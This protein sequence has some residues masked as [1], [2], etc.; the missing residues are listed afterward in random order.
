MRSAILFVISAFI[1]ITICFAQQENVWVFGTHAGLDF[2]SGSPVIMTTAIAGFGEANAS[3]CDSNGQLLFYTEGSKVWNRNHVL[4]PNGTNLTPITVPPTMSGL[5]S[6]TTST[7]QGTLIV[8]M[9]DSADKYYVFSLTSSEIGSDG[10]R[11]YYS[12]VDMTLAGGMGNVVPTQKGIYLDSGLCESLSGTIGDECNLWL[13]TRSRDGLIFKA[14]EISPSG[15]NTTP[16]ISNVGPQMSVNDRGFHLA[17]SPDRKKL[18]TGNTLFD[19]NA[20]TG[21]I[22]NPLRLFPNQA[23]SDSIAY[24]VCFSPDNSKLYV[25][26]QQ[27]FWANSRTCQFDLSAATPLAIVASAITVGYPFSATDLKLGPDQKIYFI[28]IGS[29]V[30]N[31]PATTLGR[32]EHPDLPGAACQYTINAVSFPLSNAAYFGLPNTVP[33]FKRDTIHSKQSIAAPCFTSEYTLNATAS[34]NDYLW[35][36]GAT[37]PQLTVT[38]S[39]LY[40]VSYRQAPCRYY[41][42][43]FFVQMRSPMPFTGF[44]ESGC[45]GE[46]NG[47]AWVSPAT[48]DINVYQYTW[49]DV[50]GNILQAT[51]HT[52]ADTLFHLAPGTYNVTMH[53]NNGCDT[54]FTFNLPEPGRASFTADSLICQGGT[55]QATNTSTT[56]YFTNWFW[57]FGD[58]TNSNVFNPDHIYPAPGAYKITLIA[59][60]D[61]CTDTFIRYVTV[62]PITTGNFLS[63]KNHVCIGEKIMFTPYSDSTVVSYLWDFGDAAVTTFKGEQPSH[64]YDV[65]GVFPVQLSTA[66]RACPDII[67]TD[68]IY[69]HPFPVVD[70]GRDTSICLHG[71]AVTL[72]NHATNTGG[73]FKFEWNTGDTTENIMVKHPGEYSLS[74]TNDN[75]C[76]TTETITVH[77]DCYIDIPNAFT[78][79]DD[80]ENDYFFPR[81]LLSRK[82][83]KFKMSIFNRWGELIF[84]TTNANGRGWDGRLNNKAQPVGI[85]IYIIDV[86]IDHHLAEHYTGNVTLIR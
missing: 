19:F 67:F 29:D 43:S 8:P 84:E 49:N 31:A 38:Q 86:E 60:K 28:S 24:G 9:P 3:V 10:G 4:M 22:S 1:N 82:V 71:K 57:D 17:I 30:G 81:Q 40:Y 56:G 66:F 36:T 72:Y 12:V 51:Q 47:A 39:G 59:T 18:S 52:L 27:S 7:G 76:T 58:G 11:L 64:A 32:I 6:V 23:T 75:R 62:D 20:L 45:I 61:I 70:L 78:P 48:G 25:N 54:F 44:R 46:S 34:G 2:N 79:N 35:N 14:Y 5:S 15:I 74:L 77:K 42:D 37:G 83:T 73:P 13:I 65:S 26:V 41:R 50:S 33:T 21:S 53:S 68:S 85:Y 80:G 69:V 55:L 63:D 16:V